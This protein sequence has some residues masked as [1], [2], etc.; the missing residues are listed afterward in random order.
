[1]VPVE[2]ARFVP[3]VTQQGAVGLVQREPTPGALVI[4]RLG[5]IQR[6]GP[7]G[8]PR[9]HGIAGL[10]GQELEGRTG[11]IRRGLKAQSCKGVVELPLG[12]LD[13]LPA[14]QVGWLGEVGKD[15]RLAARPA[16]LLRIIGRHGEVASGVRYPVMAKPV[17]RRGAAL[18]A[19]RHPLPQVG[20]A[21][22]ARHGRHQGRHGEVIG[23]ERQPRSAMK[24]LDA[25]EENEMTALVA[26]ENLHGREA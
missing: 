14:A 15:A 2:M 19:R 26:I 11:A 4:V 1:M 23:Q 21:L 12:M 25:V 8:M 3:Q 20:I 7:C 5:H 9:H 6:D 17:Q 18:A 13:L 16:Q 24:A 10:V 22:Q